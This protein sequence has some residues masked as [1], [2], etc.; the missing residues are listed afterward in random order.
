VVEFIVFV[1]AGRP[2]IRDRAVGGYKHFVDKG[3][4][5]DVPPPTVSRSRSRATWDI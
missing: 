3:E 1:I 5:G 4:S 2:G